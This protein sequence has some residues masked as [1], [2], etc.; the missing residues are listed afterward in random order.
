MKQSGSQLQKKSEKRMVYDRKETEYIL[1]QKIGQGGQGSVYTTHIPN[2]LI[3]IH[4]EKDAQK[5]KQW[6]QHIRWLMR[7]DFENLKLARPLEI[8]ENPA[9]I[10]GYVME[11]ISGFTPLE[12][13]IEISLT[14]LREEG[15]LEGYQKTGGLRRRLM[16]LKELA[17]TL[18]EL[19]GRGMAYGDLSPSNIFVSESSEDSQVWLIDCDNICL[20]ERESY[21]HTPR[22]AAPEIVRNESGVNIST[23]CWSFAVIALELLTHCHPFESGIAVEDVDPEIGLSQASQGE[24]PWIHDKN[25]QS[26]EWTGSGLPID[27]VTTQIRDLFDDCFNA[28]RFDISQRPSMGT[29]VEKLNS[30]LCVML[31]CIQNDQCMDFINAEGICPFCDEK[32][33]SENYLVFYHYEFYPQE[34]KKWNKS[35]YVYLINVNQRISFHS[36][37]MGTSF[38]DETPVICKIHLKEDALDIIPEAGFRIELQEGKTVSQ[39]NSKKSITRNISHEKIRYALHLC[40]KNNDDISHSVWVFNFS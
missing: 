21:I 17:K 13:L 36:G 27:I 20:K 32:Q 19:H 8:I 38:Y 29:W 6:S 40:P 10:N 37:I 14:G 18:A 39:I 4:T 15:S 28:G 23:D 11:I 24:L 2:V 22:Y 30:A 35:G 31:N 26:N 1:E 5:K 12:Q 33:S 16:L 25:D 7:Q 34:E 3:K 9:T